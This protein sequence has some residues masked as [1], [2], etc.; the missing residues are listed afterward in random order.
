MR[1]FLISF[2]LFFPAVTFAQEATFKGIPMGATQADVKQVLS[3]A[4][5]RMSFQCFITAST[6]GAS[7]DLTIGNVMAKT[8]MLSFHEG[9]MERV[10]VSLS[11]SNFDTIAAAL[12]DRYGRPASDDISRVKTG[13]G[14]EYEQRRLAWSVGDVRITYSKYGS[15]VSESNLMYIT[16]ASLERSRAA[17]EEGRKKA[18][19]DL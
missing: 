15:T 12:N 3:S 18:A 5:C 11:P 14:V 7:N 10:F 9:K 19:S 13:A 6:P 16:A 4:D 17:R 2:L 8:I 1:L